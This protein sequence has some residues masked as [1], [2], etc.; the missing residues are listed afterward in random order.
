M[1]ISKNVI[2]DLLPIYVAGEASEETRALVDDALAQDEELRAEAREMGTVPPMPEPAPPEGMGIAALKRTQTL[3]RKRTVLVGFN[4]FFTA[5]AC[6]FVHRPGG[7]VWGIPMYKATATACFLI[8]VAGWLEFLRNAVRLRD[9][10]LQPKRSR[11]PQVFWLIGAYCIVTA[12]VL[13]IDDWTH[14]SLM[15]HFSSVTVTTAMALAYIGRRLNQ[16]ESAECVPRV[17]TLLTL[18]KRDDPKEDE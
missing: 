15:H 7:V 5:L 13:V 10:G 3:L 14:W 6:A 9:T 8:A 2:R 17:E 12:L 4:Y 18:A 1:S 16:Y 11:L